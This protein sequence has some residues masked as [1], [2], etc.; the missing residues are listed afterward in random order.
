MERTQNANKYTFTEPKVREDKM[1]W[2]RGGW[3]GRS[4]YTMSCTRVATT[5][6]SNLISS[7]M[8]LWIK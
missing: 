7:R 6:T 5:N 4:W 8:T 2:G 3:N 1:R